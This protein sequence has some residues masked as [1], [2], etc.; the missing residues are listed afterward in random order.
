[1]I[2]I[3]EYVRMVQN[4]QIKPGAKINIVRET[5]STA[6]IDG[7]WGFGQVIAKDSMQIA[8]K[9]AERCSVSSVGVFHCNHIG[10]LGE[11][12][13]MAAENDMIG[14]IMCNSGPAGGWMAPY[15]GR[16]RRLSANPISGAVPAGKMKPLVFD[17]A[18][19]VVAEG[20]VRVRYES[21][22]KVPEG[23]IVDKEGRPT[24]NP[25]D[26]YEG[27][28]LLPFGGHKG[29]CLAL[30]LDIMGGA[31]TGAGCTSSKEYEWGNGTFMIVIDIEAFSP[32]KR[33]KKRVDELF[34]KI[35]ETPAAPG[36]NSVL[37]PGEPEFSTEEKRLKEG[38]FIPEKTWQSIVNVAEEL[39]VRIT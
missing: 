7:N 36:F 16:E 13:M 22:E 23:W 10:R 25:G 5:P 34:Q 1:V 28:A 8:I 12:S 11:Y 20:K 21:G 38:I 26:L 37:V 35:K 32:L 6:L 9:K 17:Y 15:G 39:G 31:L 19:S 4:G 3:V 30:F 2:R 18:T 33:F 14:I 29:Y 24:N 27:G